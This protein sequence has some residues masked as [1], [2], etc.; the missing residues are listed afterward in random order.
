MS[1]EKNFFS[2]YKT[3]LIIGIIMVITL[4]FILAW[5]S[6]G[7]NGFVGWNSFLWIGL[8][9]FMLLMGCWW[10]AQ[11][12]ERSTLPKSLFNLVILAIIL[13]LSAGVVWYIA[14]PA[15]GHGSPAEKS[16]Y[17]MA[18]A[19]QRDQAA[20][21]LAQSQKPLW[22]A[23]Q[24]QRMVDQYGGFL[25][26][27]ALV[28]RY[29]AG[30]VHQPLQIV[31]LVATISG[32]AVLFT[33]LFTR[34]LWNEKTAW[35]AAWLLA[36]FPEAVLLG[37]SQMREAITITL[38]IGAFY[39]LVAFL[40]QRVKVYLLSFQA[41]YRYR[42]AWFVGLLMLVLVFGGI[43]FALSQ[44]TPEKI[45]NPIAMVNWWFSKS[46]D[47]QAHLTEQASG[48]IQAIFDRTPAWTHPYLLVAYGVGQPLLPAALVV[49]S[50]SPIWQAI[51]I[52]RAFG[53]TILLA[54]LIYA[55]IRAWISKASL[56]TRML[57]ILVWLTILVASFRGG[58]DQWDNPRYRVTFLGLQVALAAWGWVSYR[59]SRDTLFRYS[60]IWVTMILLWF[61]P[62]YL[63]REF[64][65]PWAV[66]DAFKTF[67]IGTISA[68]LFII[69]DWARSASSTNS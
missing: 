46:A 67:A 41:M 50:Q 64:H 58:G 44:F 11:K 1:A 59:Q 12:T 35:V 49:T 16:G 39:G 36:L 57:T 40:K 68:I 31:L 18:D 3:Y 2:K 6:S 8:V 4:A 28:Y 27:S 60:V 25:F 53:W 54:L 29:M 65:L 47:W 20:W 37:G 30:D 63:Q 62:W 24:N 43:W 38:T 26:T 13:R 42:Y 7:F 51:A 56:L 66:G 19:F 48:K 9:G 10:L 69:W 45:T 34:H 5:I 32:L 61:V 14:L 17:V 33:W 22:R 23:F 21:K 15:F 52:W 55:T